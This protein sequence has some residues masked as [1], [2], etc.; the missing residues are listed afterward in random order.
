MIPVRLSYEAVVSDDEK[1]A[2]ALNL[3]Y[4]RKA[5]DEAK[6]RYFPDAGS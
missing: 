4:T 3:I 6:S 2:E 1:Q 5:W